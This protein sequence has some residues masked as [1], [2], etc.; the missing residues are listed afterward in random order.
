MKRLF[1]FTF[2][3]CVLSNTQSWAEDTLYK[4][5]FLSGGLGSV[6][7]SLG[8]LQ[9]GGGGGAVHPTGVGMSGELGFLTHMNYFGDWI[10]VGEINGNYHFLKASPSQKIIP[11]VGGGYTLYFRSGAAHQ[12]NIG[13][14]IDYWTTPTKGFRFEIRDHPFDNSHLVSIRAAFIFR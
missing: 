13:G 12:L 1:L 6:N 11:F 14:G 10:G 5:G 2:F 8:V 4:Y 7:H 3:F 9:L